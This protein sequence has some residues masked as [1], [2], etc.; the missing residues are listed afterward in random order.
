MFY[1]A[2]YNW[3]HDYLFRNEPGSSVK[4]VPPVHCPVDKEK[5]KHDNA[6]KK[7]KKQDTTEFQSHLDEKM[8]K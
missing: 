1:H 8:N 2:N 6:N 7:R 3:Y 5:N 4:P